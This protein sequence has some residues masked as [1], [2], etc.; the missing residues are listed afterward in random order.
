MMPTATMKTV[1]E[2]CV[3]PRVSPGEAWRIF[4]HWVSDEG[5]LRAS[6]GDSV[7]IRSSCPDCRGEL[8]SFIDHRLV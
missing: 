3:I 5:I 8:L 1:I 6:H 7:E 2:I 4:Y